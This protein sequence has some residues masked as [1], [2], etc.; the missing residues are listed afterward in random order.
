MGQQQITAFTFDPYVVV[1]R[2]LQ[3]Q[4]GTLNKVVGMIFNPRMAQTHVIRNE[5]EHE[6]QPAL[7]EP[8]AE[9]R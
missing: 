5:V 9:P 2:T 1:W 8:L 7:S 3:I 4:L 6:F